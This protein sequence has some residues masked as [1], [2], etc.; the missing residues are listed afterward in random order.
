MSETIESPEPKQ[1]HLHV[2]IP[3]YGPMD[4][5]T[6]GSL[7]TLRQEVP[8]SFDIIG[9]AEL[10]IARTMLVDRAPKEADIFLWIDNDMVFVPQHFHRMVDILIT[11]PELGLVSATAVRRDGSNSYVVNWKKNRKEFY[12]REEVYDIATK[13]I[14]NR[15][16]V[17]VDVTGLAFT[18]MWP[19]VF[20]QLKKPWFRPAWK[21]TQFYGEDSTLIKGMQKIGYEP[22]VDFGSHVGHIGTQVYLPQ[23]PKEVLEK[24]ENEH[25]NRHQEQGNDEGQGPNQGG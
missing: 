21:K 18:V 6:V 2:M 23:V 25:N 11:N 3:C 10:A 20:K 5:Q 9:T 24:L 19:K 14:G 8:F 16:V 4:G 17:P 13:H 15:A 22:S 7:L 1:L 12:S